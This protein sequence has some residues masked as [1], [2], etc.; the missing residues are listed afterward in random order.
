MA[1]VYKLP[2]VLTAEPGGGFVVTSPALPELITEGDTVEDALNNV[3]DAL[4]AVRE[5]YE[6]HGRPFPP[7]LSQDLGSSPIQFDYLIDAA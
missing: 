2:L 3:R 6:D 5:I 4:R 7:D 1:S